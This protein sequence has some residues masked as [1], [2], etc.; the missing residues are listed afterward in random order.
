MFL[1]HDLIFYQIKHVSANDYSYYYSDFLIKENVFS[2]GQ[3]S[4]QYNERSTY[5]NL[6]FLTIFE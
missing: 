3:F 2:R 6:T 4:S 5:I 1:F